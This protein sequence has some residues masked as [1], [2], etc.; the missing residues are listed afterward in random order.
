MN[1]KKP[2]ILFF[3]FTLIGG[4]KENVGRRIKEA[5]LKENETEPRQ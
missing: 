3:M 1:H 4:S 2:V 5:F